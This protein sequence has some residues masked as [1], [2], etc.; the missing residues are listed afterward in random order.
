VTLSILRSAYSC[1]LDYL[2]NMGVGA[3]MTI[4]LMKDQK[5]WG[6]IACHH[7]TPK[8]VPYELRKACEFLGR[9][10]FAEIFTREEEADYN[11]RMK[12]AHVQSA[13]I[14]YMSQADNFIDGL[15]QHEPNLLDLADAKGAA[16]CFNGQW[17]TIGRTPEAEELALLAQDLERSNAELK[18]FAYVASHVSK[19]YDLHVNCYIS[20]SRNLSQL[21]KIV[22]GIEEF[23]LETARL[24]LES[25]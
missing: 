10:I 21:F 5:L 25:T 24:P 16:I 3:S 14:E 11:Y 22:Q 8:Y 15:I 18:K 20:K 7:R 13:L 17:T 1:H 4:S 12:L 9:V 2:H 19:S 6:L 23:W